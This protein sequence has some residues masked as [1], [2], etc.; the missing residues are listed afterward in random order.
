[1]NPS[2]SPLDS[3]QDKRKAV[4][5]GHG[6][7]TVIGLLRKRRSKVRHV[8]EL[9]EADTLREKGCGDEPRYSFRE[10]F[11]LGISVLRTITHKSLGAIVSASMLLI[12]LMWQPAFANPQAGA[13]AQ[14]ATPA[15]Q[16]PTQAQPVAPASG[17]RT[18]TDEYGRHVT[19]PLEAKRVVSL[20]PNLT[21][22][23]YALGLE[24]KLVG[25]TSY[26]DTPQAAKTKPHVGDTI[27]PS[28][29][30][31]VALHPDLVLAT[32]I[33]R[34]DTVDGLSRLGIPV[35]T[36][37]PHTVLE[38]LQSTR[39]VAE[40]LGAAEQGK[41]FA[42]R[43]QGRLDDLHAR[44]SDRPLVHV[45]FVVWED[46]L[47]TVGQNTFIADALRWAGAESVV[48]SKQDWPV[49]AFEEV[50]RLQPEYI[51]TASNHTGEGKSS[52]E[53]FRAKP[54]WKNL[55]AVEAGHV[56]V[57]SDE[58]DKPSPGLIDAIEDLAHQIHPEVFTEKSD[59]HLDQVN[60]APAQSAH[61]C[62]LGN[63]EAVVCAR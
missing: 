39:H 61:C 35:Y 19:V 28:L 10:A 43:L 33:N 13:A 5:I 7:A 41:A 38:M 62:P 20:A 52:L 1:M 51:V 25:D 3:S 58:V 60:A 57:I 12:M 22:T 32:A 29:E 46:P 21:E 31:I 56:A 4:K 47:F 15:P 24:D 48:M 53:E 6:P 59:A 45:L 37:D 11:L 27:H 40:L 30:A 26:C 34:I 23:I 17:T 42:D 55:Q 2:K 9:V 8:P 50:V 49:V 14:T 63:G 18:L 36:T 44:L 54:L 16:E